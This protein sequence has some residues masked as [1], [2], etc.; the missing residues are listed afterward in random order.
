[1]SVWIHSQGYEEDA[2]RLRPQAHKA[3]GSSNYN[4][5][6]T[7]IKGGDFTLAGFTLVHEREYTAIIR[8]LSYQNFQQYAA[9]SQSQAYRA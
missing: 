7:K 8:L 4:K 9:F 5:H 2:T 3:Q 6:N 1:M